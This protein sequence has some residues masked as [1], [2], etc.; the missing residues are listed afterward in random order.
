[1][2]VRRQ[3]G[4]SHPNHIILGFEIFVVNFGHFL[5]NGHWIYQFICYKLPPIYYPVTI[6]FII[7]LLPLNS[8]QTWQTNSG[9]CDCVGWKKPQLAA[10]ITVEKTLLSLQPRDYVY[11]SVQNITK[12]ETWAFSLVCCINNNLHSSSLQKITNLGWSIHLQCVSKI[13]MIARIY[14]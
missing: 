7:L 14:I 10:G 12:P 11:N 3:E 5:Q 4:G 2:V 9:C 6:K 1:M 8:P 13:H